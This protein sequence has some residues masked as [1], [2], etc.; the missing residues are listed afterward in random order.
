MRAVRFERYGG[1]EVLE[2]VQVEDPTPGRGQVLVTNISKS[3]TRS[4]R[5]C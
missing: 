4:A 2:V 5:S 3:V 1:P